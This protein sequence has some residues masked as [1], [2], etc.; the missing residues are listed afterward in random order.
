M[1]RTIAY[2]PAGILTCVILSTAVWAPKRA[3]AQCQPTG[4][5]LQP[6][7]TSTSSSNQPEFFDRPNFIVAG[8][9]DTT[10][11]GGHGSEPAWRAKEAL[12]KDA[13]S[14]A[15]ARTQP[16]SSAAT[17]LLADAAIREPQNFDVNYRLG[18][19]LV[20]EGKPQEA[21]PYLENALRLS[22]GKPQKTAEV[23]SLLAEVDEKL[24]NALQAVRHYQRAAELDPSETNLFNWGAELLTHRAPEPAIE[25]FRR[26]NH[27]FPGSVRMLIALGVAWYAHGSADQAVQCLCAASD[28]NPADPKPYLFLGKTISLDT[29]SSPEVALKLA[30]FVKLAPDNAWANYYYALALW[31]Q[32]KGP[33]DG[34][35]LPQI[36]SL[37]EKSV[38]LDP[39]LA[40]AS[41][42]LG[43][44]HS[45]R[46][47]YTQ[48]IAA[49]QKAIAAEPDLEAAHYRLAQAYRLNGNKEQ[50][51]KETGIYQ[52][53]SK[54]SE[55]QAERQR[56][57]IQEFVYSLR[58]K[59][60][61]AQA[62]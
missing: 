16:A 30:R 26:G 34:K 15:N 58:E 40:L 61:P 53:L 12:T 36:Q 57:E 20:N 56:H 7:T 31:Q 5:S 21:Q 25:V 22:E 37:L 59:S 29:A 60:L 17:K 24:D 8:V 45:E 4:T 33:E 19:L 18:K 9:T 48:A 43:I 52:E 35:Y 50:A 55:A 44:L 2:R 1:N 51:A 14:L 47:N 6:P 23:H 41:V 39:K 3:K 46:K 11:I 54:Q 42:Q 62:K 27:L 10:N 32:R 13:A 28:L 49:Y 38:Q